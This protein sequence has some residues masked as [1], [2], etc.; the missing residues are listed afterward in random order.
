LGKNRKRHCQQCGKDKMFHGKKVKV[1]ESH[2][3]LQDQTG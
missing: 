1:G 2:I 3:G